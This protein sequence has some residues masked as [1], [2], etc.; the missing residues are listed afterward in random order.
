MSR[1]F[2]CLAL[3]VLGA[4]LASAAEDLA[5]ILRETRWI[6]FAPT[7]F[8][9]NSSPVVLPSDDSLRL[10]LATLRTA[11]FSGLITYGGDFQAVPVPRIA[12]ALGFQHLIL[13][14]WDPFNARELEAAVKAVRSHDRL[15][16]GVIVGNE[17]L[18][19]G[20]YTVN[21]LCAV[22]GRVQKMTGKPVSTT[23][24]VDLILS[25]PKVAQCSTFLTVNAHPFFSNQ[26]LPPE[27]V[28]WTQSMERRSKS[29]SRQTNIVQGGG[30]ADGRCRG[31]E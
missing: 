21:D 25:E 7:A 15:I 6:S 22:M 12:E 9:P 5:G 11:G 20:R 23:E 2:Y 31:D 29:I 16:S 14:I 1:V 18:L 3:G 27:A 13:G 28:Q 26:K 8:N 10:D 19:N 30:P 24:P 17:G 4:S